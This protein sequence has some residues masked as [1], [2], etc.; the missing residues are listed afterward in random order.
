MPRVKPAIKA[1]FMPGRSQEGIYETASTLH[2]GPA[3]PPEVSA[4]KDFACFDGC[5]EDKRDA[6]TN[7]LEVSLLN[8]LQIKD[9]DK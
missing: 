2:L 8:F 9:L 5:D 7:P 1:G 6:F 3:G 4:E